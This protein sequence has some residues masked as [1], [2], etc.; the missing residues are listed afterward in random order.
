MTK[1]HEWS[2]ITLIIYQESQSA[3][4][5]RSKDGENEELGDVTVDGEVKMSIVTHTMTTNG[6]CFESDD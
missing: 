4:P 3:A 6:I 5:K 1:L 2:R